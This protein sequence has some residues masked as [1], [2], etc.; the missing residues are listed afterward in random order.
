VTGFRI[1]NPT[2]AQIIEMSRAAF[3]EDPA[4]DN[5]RDRHRGCARDILGGYM[6]AETPEAV[7]LLAAYQDAAERAEAERVARDH[8]ARAE[9]DKGWR[10][11]QERREAASADP[12]GRRVL[13]LRD[14]RSGNI[15]RVSVPEDW[16]L[17]SP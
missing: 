15:V 11:F 12:I 7:A 4:D 1:H 17:G 14:A 2:P 5:L 13:M 16:I 6:K 10:E 8:A 9:S 3:G